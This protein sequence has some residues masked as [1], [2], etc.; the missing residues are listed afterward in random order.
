M[1]AQGHKGGP[2]KLKTALGRSIYALP[3]T[4]QC[5]KTFSCTVGQFEKQVTLGLAS[6]VYAVGLAFAG[7]KSMH[8]GCSGRE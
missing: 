7:L 5:M 8:C 3:S 2:Q 6:L 1:M 4:Q